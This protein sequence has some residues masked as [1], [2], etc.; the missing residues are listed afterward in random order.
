MKRLER[1]PVPVL[2]AFVGALTLSNVYSGMGYPWVRHVTMWAATIILL[3]YIVKIVMYPGVCKKEY[4]TVVPCS[5][6]AAFTMILMILGSYYY[7]YVPALGKGMWALA[8]VIHAV[9][10]LIFTYRNMIKN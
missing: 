9:H 2:P 1:M 10:I 6:Y 3:L 5:L 7:D 8:T 4:T